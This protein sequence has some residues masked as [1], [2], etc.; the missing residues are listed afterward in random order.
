[1][2]V[3]A[4]LALIVSGSFAFAQAPFKVPEKE[5]DAALKS[6]R[7]WR[8][9]DGTWEGEVRYVAAPRPEWLKQRQPFRV[10]LKGDEPKVY[11]RIKEQEWQEVG[12]VYRGFKADELTFVIHV[13]GADGVWTEHNVVLLSRRTENTAEVFIQRAVNNWAGKSLPGED[14]IYGDSRTGTVRRQ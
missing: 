5:R 4:L 3:I 13:Y 2:R 7:S 12:T 11:V 1:M 9:F 14:L 8:G 10:V 6:I